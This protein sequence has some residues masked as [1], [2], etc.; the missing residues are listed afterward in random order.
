[1]CEMLAFSSEELVSVDTLLGWAALLERYGLAGYGWG[2][3]WTDGQ[4]LYRYR[5]VEG[6][7]NDPKA[8]DVLARLT[9]RRGF[10]HL[11]RPS[12]MTTVAFVNTQP[13]MDDNGDWAFAHNGYLERHRD[14]RSRYQGELT[15]T[16]DSEVGFRYWCEQT[17]S[18]ADRFAATHEALGGKAN[19]MGLSRAGDL[20]VYAGNS[21]NRVFSF[22]LGA[23][24]L[25]TTSL[26]SGDRFLFEGLFPEARDIQEMSLGDTIMMP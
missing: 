25:A 22:R 24:S 14:F 3:V 16:S 7:Q 17:G 12:L 10:I 21:E 2:M 15:G 19:F 20:G 8:D 6:L 18:I 11:R 5:S 23:I 13:Y 26:H 4:T 9:L 1:M